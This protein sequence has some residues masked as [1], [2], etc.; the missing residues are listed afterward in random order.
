MKRLCS[1]RSFQPHSEHLPDTLPISEY[2]HRTH[3]SSLRLRTRLR[4]K[5]APQ[6]RHR[7]N[8]GKKSGSGIPVSIMEI[9]SQI[10]K[11]KADR[12]ML[13]GVR[14]SRES[15]REPQ[16]GHVA[17]ESGSVPIVRLAVR[18]SALDD[19]LVSIVLPPHDNWLPQRSIWTHWLKGTL[20]SWRA[21]AHVAPPEISGCPFRTWVWALRSFDDWIGLLAL[22]R[23][24]CGD[25]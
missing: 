22:W 2:P 24:R 16:C 13:A 25:G 21:K 9:N 6:R 8:T 4:A 18:R 11:L 17:F 12:A 20:A 10:V 15:L 14:H 3:S 7:R 1:L 19:T 5:T 23:F